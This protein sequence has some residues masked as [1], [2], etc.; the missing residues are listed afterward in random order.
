MIFEK[1]AS[2]CTVYEFTMQET[3]LSNSSVK[4]LEGTKSIFTA[5]TACLAHFLVYAFL[6]NKFET[7]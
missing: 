6:V 4:D 1:S 5:C 7:N 2:I 3:F